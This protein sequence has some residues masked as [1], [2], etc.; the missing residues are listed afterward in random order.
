VPIEAKRAKDKNDFTLL[1]YVMFYGKGK[2]VLELVQ[3]LV[4]LYPDSVKATTKMGNLAIHMMP[5]YDGNPANC[6]KIQS[7]Q[8]AARLFLIKN[9]PAGLRA[10]D[11]DGVMPLF[12][13]IRHGYNITARAIVETFPEAAK[14]Q[15]SHGQI[16]LHLSLDMPYVDASLVEVLVYNYPAGF[17]LLDNAGKSPLGNFL[18]R[19]NDQTLEPKKIIIIETIAKA[20]PDL[21]QTAC[22]QGKLFNE[23]VSI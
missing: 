22:H 2:G 12:R 4:Y 1:H 7:D 9:Y 8:L 23:L 15:N 16:P 19:G 21:F 3:H 17:R 13:A 14:L 18:L 11:S 10:L 5:Q 6:T 20:A